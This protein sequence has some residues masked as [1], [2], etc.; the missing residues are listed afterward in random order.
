MCLAI[1]KPIGASLPT[2]DIL[3]TAHVSNNDG[4]GFSYY[5]SGLWRTI[6]GLYN[7]DKYMRLL[8]KHIPE[9]ELVPVV[10]HFR[11]A[12]HGTVNVANAQPLDVCKGV[13]WAHNGI[14]D[15][16]GADGDK[17]DSRIMV[18]TVVRPLVKATLYTTLSH[19]L[20]TIA[21]NSNSRFLLAIGT[22][23]F[24]YGTWNLSSDGCHYSNLNHKHTYTVPRSVYHFDVC[25]HCGASAMCMFDNE[26]VMFLCSDCRADAKTNTLETDDSLCE[27][28]HAPDGTLSHFQH[29]TAV[30][31]QECWNSLFSVSP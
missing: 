13:L 21:R 14:V 27:W 29:E 9:P 10:L 5:H 6:K 15:I 18:D 4:C 28:C 31:C 26:S 12:T 30:L 2:D 20:D 11:L 17:S 22:E 16:D 3:A 24:M 19:T 7:F 23:V 8:N 1:Y 25:D